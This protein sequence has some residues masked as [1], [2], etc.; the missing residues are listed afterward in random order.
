[1]DITVNPLKGRGVNWLMVTLYYSS[2]TYIF[3]SLHLGTLAL[4][5][6]HLEM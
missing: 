2:L 4:S 3:N 5:P 1:M 6:E